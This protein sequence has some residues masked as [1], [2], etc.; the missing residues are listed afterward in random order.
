M[1]DSNLGPVVAIIGLAIVIGLFTINYTLEQQST[2]ICQASPT[3]SAS[4]SEASAQSSASASSS[5]VSLSMYCSS[6]T[7]QFGN[8]TAAEA[9][10][11]SQCPGSISNI[12]PYG[13]AFAL[14]AAIASLVYVLIKRNL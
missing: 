8:Y 12:I 6:L 13:L 11:G 14:I 3:C 10:I 9:Y 7:S 1:S 2:E 4:V 5:S